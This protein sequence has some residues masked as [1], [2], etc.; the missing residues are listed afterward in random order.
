LSGPVVLAAPVAPV[1]RRTRSVTSRSGSMAWSTARGKANGGTP[2]F[3]GEIGRDGVLCT[4]GAPPQV[5]AGQ[6][7][8]GGLSFPPTKYVACGGTVNC[9]ARSKFGPGV[10]SALTRPRESRFQMVWPRLGW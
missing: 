10:P 1:V 7:L 5:G 6:T 8:E 4:F 9:R 3:V 2:G